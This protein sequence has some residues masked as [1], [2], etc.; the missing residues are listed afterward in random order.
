MKLYQTRKSVFRSDLASGEIQKRLEH[1][2]QLYNHGYH[3]DEVS[4]G[5]YT[6]GVEGQGFRIQRYESFD[7]YSVPSA[8][9]QIVPEE[10]GCRMELEFRQS[11]K[12]HVLFNVVLI[13][14]MLISAIVI[15]MLVAGK[16]R[17]NQ[18]ELMYGPFYGIGVYGLFWLLFLYHAVRTERDLARQLAMRVVKAE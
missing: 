17:E 16:L 11:R 4:I 3:A 7:Q 10:K 6:G 9:L 13:C 8:Y 12:M 1:L 14:T 18:R 5:Y 15:L 2:L